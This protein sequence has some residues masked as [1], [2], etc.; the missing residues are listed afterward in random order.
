MATTLSSQLLLKNIP[1]IENF[2]GSKDQDPV[3]WLENM[4][5]IFDATKTEPADRRRLLPL[6]LTDEAK[7]WYRSASFAEDYVKFKDQFLSA[8]MSPLYKLQ[9]SA[10]LTARKQGLEESVQSYYYDVIE[11]CHRFN[12][13]MDEDEKLVHLLRGFK[14][15]IQQHLTI[16][17]GKSC[18]ELFIQAK[19]TEAMV[20]LIQQ[21]DGSAPDSVPVEISAALRQGYPSTNS[22]DHVPRNS[23]RFHNTKGYNRPNNKNNQTSTSQWSKKSL[24]KV[25]CHNCGGY[26]HYAS[27]CPSQLN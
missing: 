1:A 27:Q 7:Q 4:E 19:Q 21:N 22:H 11:L 24:G 16:S 5:E 2:S 3:G 6:H 8:F 9:L 25:Q 10:K 26:G 23:P 13:R 12:P 15:S 18:H 20:K 14:P 17:V